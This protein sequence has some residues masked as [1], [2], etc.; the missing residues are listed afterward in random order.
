MRAD[1]CRE[2]ILHQHEYNGH[3]PAVLTIPWQ[4]DSLVHSPEVHN[5]SY[6]GVDRKP[7]TGGNCSHVSPL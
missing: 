4:M 3:E 6:K 2:V 1:A 7:D 5:R